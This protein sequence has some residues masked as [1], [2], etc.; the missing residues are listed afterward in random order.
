[1]PEIA[2]R[3]ASLVTCLARPNGAP[4]SLP[5]ERF[6][7]FACAFH[8]QTAPKLSA[9]ESALSG[10]SDGWRNSTPQSAYRP[11]PLRYFTL[12]RNHFG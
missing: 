8:A 3:A 4:R 10:D 7:A 2:H 5:C 6:R 11:A 1:M 9:D 12:S